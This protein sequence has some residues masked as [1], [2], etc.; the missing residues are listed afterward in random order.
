MILGSQWFHYF[1]CIYEVQ[2]HILPYLTQNGA[3]QTVVCSKTSMIAEASINEIWN[4]KSAVWVHLCLARKM[5]Q[6]KDIT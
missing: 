5:G 2:N 6:S 1:N 3:D 4:I